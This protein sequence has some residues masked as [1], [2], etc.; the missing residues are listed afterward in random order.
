MFGG[1]KLKT[2]IESIFI[3]LALLAAA[4]VPVTAFINE[5]LTKTLSSGAKQATSWVVA[6]GLAFLGYWKGVGIF[7]DTTIL[8]TVITG[9]AAG[10]VS[11]GI[12][13]ISFVQDIL[14]FLKLNKK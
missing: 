9:V 3:S 6:V 4:V 14:T 12:F 11:N 13:D 8:W 5:H 7:A 10:F 2:M 1:I